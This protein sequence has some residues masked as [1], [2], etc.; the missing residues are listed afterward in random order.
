MP[1]DFAEVPDLDFAPD[2]RLFGGGSDWRDVAMVVGTS[3]ADVPYALGFTEAANA[4]VE[5]GLETHMQDFV[6]FPALYCYR[7]AAELTMKEIVYLWDRAQGRHRTVIKTHDLLVVWDRA[8]G[9]LEEVWPDGDQSQLD[10]M[11]S[12]IGELATVD[13]EGEQFRY[14][15]DR[16]GDA[17][18]LPDE[19]RRTDLRHVATVMNKLLGNLGGAVDGI[20]E[21]RRAAE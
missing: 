17:R 19:I 6:F 18:V 2:E 20:E 4:L 10:A 15:R 16:A 8:R 12:I 21:M 7:H 5:R 13:P 3:S 9:V 1:P 14:D 11:G